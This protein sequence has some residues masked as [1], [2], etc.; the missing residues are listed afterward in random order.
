MVTVWDVGRISSSSS[1]N[2]ALI[3]EL[4]FFGLVYMGIS[5]RVINLALVE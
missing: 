5:L 1:R 2:T 3:I 4:H